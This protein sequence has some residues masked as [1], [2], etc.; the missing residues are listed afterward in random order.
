MNTTQIFKIIDNLAEIGVNVLTFTGGEPTLR[1]D[2]PK[3]L[4]H[5]GINHNFIS[6]IAT[7]GFLMP[8]LLKEHKF[9]GLDYILTSI[10]YPNAKQ[11]DRMRGIKVF[12]NV[13]K[14]IKI[15]NQRDIKVIISIVAM[16]DNLYL[17]EDICELG[18]RLNCTMEI[19]PCE[20][21]IR[22][23]PDNRCQITNINNIIP[24]ILEWASIIKDLKSKFKNILT[25]PISIQVVSNGGFGGYPNYYQDILRCHVAEAFLFVSND[26][27][28]YL[29]CKI[30]PVRR[31]NIFKYNLSD[32]YNSKEVREI[33]MKQDSYEFCNGC[34]LGCAIAAS[35]PTNLKGLYIKFFKGI[36]NGNL[37]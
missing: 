16:K 4:Y 2:L 12:D 36:L 14:M 8:K 23:L 29:P 21:I 10:D 33:M 1:K 15:V 37:R 27:F 5:A 35:I 25:D 19:Y 17:L 18:E 9:E 20:D 13:I 30:N 6:G 26:G 11:H 22:N 7:N 31:I 3:I 24:N 34:R 28:I 32:L